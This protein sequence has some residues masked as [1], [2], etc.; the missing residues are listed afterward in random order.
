MRLLVS[1]STRNDCVDTPLAKGDTVYFS[2]WADRNC[3]PPQ[4]YEL[5]GIVVNASYIPTEDISL[6]DSDAFD[7]TVLYC[8]LRAGRRYV[9]VSVSENRPWVFVDA[10]D[11]RTEPTPPYVRKAWGDDGE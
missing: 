8:C 10:T 5:R 1:G 6:E 7:P 2:V 9:F 3:G 11:V 4:E